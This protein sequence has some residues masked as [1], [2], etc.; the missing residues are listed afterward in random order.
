M[1][2]RIKK[3]KYKDILLSIVKAEIEGNFKNK[4]SFLHNLS[5]IDF[6]HY[7]H[8]F[9]GSFILNFKL[10]NYVMKEYNSI[11]DYLSALEIIQFLSGL[12]N[13]VLVDICCLHFLYEYYKFRIIIVFRNFMYLYNLKNTNINFSLTN[14]FKSSSWLEREIY[15]LFGVS[16]INH[17]NLRRILTDY[18]FK[19]FP[20]RKDFPVFGYCELVFDYERQHLVYTDIVFNQSWRLFFFARQWKK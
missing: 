17:L 11:H 6:K 18:G 15:D 20:L 8:L 2:R 5:I 13:N 10:K 9:I 14:S 4:Y 3:D 16:W 19:G 7:V 1:R 12:K